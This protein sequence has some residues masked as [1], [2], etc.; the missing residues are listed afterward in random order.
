MCEPQASG[1]HERVTRDDD[2]VQ[3]PSNGAENEGSVRWMVPIELEH[4]AQPRA[5]SQ[6]NDG[7]QDMSKVQPQ[8]GADYFHATLRTAAL[9]ELNRRALHVPIGTEDTAVALARPQQCVTLRAYVEE[10]ACVGRHL[11]LGLG[12]AGGTG[13]YGALQHVSGPCTTTTV[14]LADPEKRDQRIQEQCGAR[15]IERRNAAAKE[16]AA[17]NERSRCLNALI[18]KD[19]RILRMTA[20]GQAKP[21]KAARGRQHDYAVQGDRNR[22]RPMRLARERQ[23][24][25]HQR[26]EEQQN[27]I[28][29]QQRVIDRT[30]CGD[31]VVMRDPHHEYV[32]ERQEVG[33]VHGPEVPEPCQGRFPRHLELEHHYCQDDGDDAIRERLQAILVHLRASPG[34]PWRE[35]APSLPSY[36]REASRRP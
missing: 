30:N 36:R 19:L 7:N 27:A 21:D 18:C 3:Q 34:L 2:D 20:G 6:R 26:H 14:Y 29:E 5:R 16:G 17:E 4:D 10:D 33:D 9:L 11:L 32:A 24:E 35:S 8:V 13:D 1:E 25:R 28:G 31:D 15:R 22:L 12:A 23:G